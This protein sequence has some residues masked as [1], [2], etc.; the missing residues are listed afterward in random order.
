LLKAVV[1]KNPV[2]PPPAE[3]IVGVPVVYEDKLDPEVHTGASDLVVDAVEGGAEP[4]SVV[5]GSPAL[6]RDDQAARDN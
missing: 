3:V 2:G 1:F 4:V 6:R 5:I